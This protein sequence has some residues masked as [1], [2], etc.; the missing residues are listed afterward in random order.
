MPHPAMR[1]FLFYPAKDVVSTHSDAIP[2]SRSVMNAFSRTG[3]MIKQGQPFPAA[4]VQLLKPLIHIVQYRHA[5]FPLDIHDIAVPV[6]IVKRITQNLI[7]RACMIG[8]ACLSLFICK[9]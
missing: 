8:H 9:E 6:R 5:V 4:P 7:I 2:F 3:R 1:H